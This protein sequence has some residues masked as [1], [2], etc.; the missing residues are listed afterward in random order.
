MT[1]RYIALVDATG[2][3]RLPNAERLDASLR[4]L[5]LHPMLVSGSVK[6]FA[7]ASTSCQLLSD[8]SVVI[9]PVFPR[10][11][12]RPG[13]EPTRQS[14]AL[15]WRETCQQLLDRYW[16]D[17]LLIQA[18]SNG[19]ASV[20][21][22]RDPSG[23]MPCYYAMSEGVGFVTS[24]ISLAIE[25][26]LYRRRIDWESI[27]HCLSYPRIKTRATALRDVSELL[28]GCSLHVAPSTVTTNQE[29][30][31]WTFVAKGRRFADLDDAALAVRGAVTSV[32]AAWASIDD[33]ILMELSGGLDSSIVAACL[34]GV[35]ERVTC[36]NVVAPVPGGDERQYATQL[37]ARLGLSL[38]TEHLSLDAECVDFDQPASAVSPRMGVLQ[39]AVAQVMESVGQRNG[40]SSYYSGGGGDTVFCYLTGA[41]PAADAVRERG[42]R[43][44]LA[45][46]KDLTTLHQCTLWKAARLTMRKLVR[47]V[48]PPSTPDTLFLNPSAAITAVG[49]HP[50]FN[51]PRDAL[52]GDRERIFDLAGNQLF[53]D[54]VFRGQNRSIRLPLLSQPVVEACLAVPSWM[55]ISGGRNRSVARAAFEDVLPPDVL[56]RRSKGTFVAYLGA[57]FRRNKD[58]IR[59]RL[60]SGQLREQRFLDADALKRF[61]ESEPPPRDQTFT[62]VLALLTVENWLRHQA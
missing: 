1:Y 10:D 31:P 32:V 20:N 33:A 54:I 11:S 28:P 38:E 58:Q 57:L 16:G 39:H 30:T 37:A 44:G 5:G 47:P 8:D 15:A 49:E 2:R 43:A 21:L 48:R 60:L 19:T 25:L 59:T 42:V 6:V 36:C 26:G 40:A 9:G 24:D 12:W 46:I 18:A 3:W 41:T 29:W 23:G 34:A 45:A 62:R 14:G 13:I 17:Y 7:A 35:N 55:W 22:M 50:W 4:R 27:A 56:N 52:A 53:R 51:A 61:F